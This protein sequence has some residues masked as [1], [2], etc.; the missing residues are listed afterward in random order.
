MIPAI[1]PGSDLRWITAPARV[2]SEKSASSGIAIESRNPV[3]TML[4]HTQLTRRPCRPNSTA[5]DFVNITT[6]PFD[7]QYAAL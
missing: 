7:A 5:S 3:S 4:G 1:S 6:P 2:N